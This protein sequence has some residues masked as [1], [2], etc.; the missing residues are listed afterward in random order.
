MSN[1]TAFTV[2][3]I[4]KFVCEAGKS[5][6]FF[7]DASTPGLGLR[8][9]K[10]GAKSYIF[11]SSKSGRITI[12]DIKTW[13]LPEAK[14]RATELKQ[15]VDNG[16]DPRIVAQQQT[17]KQQQFVAEQKRHSI[18]VGEVWP[19][20]VQVNQ[21]KWGA[22]YRFM[23]TKL[24]EAGGEPWKRGKGT[25]VPGPLVPVMALRMCD[26]T[27][28]WIQDWLHDE[29]TVKKR[30]TQARQG[31]VFLRAFYNWCESEAEYRGLIPAETFISKRVKERV[32]KDKVK[33]N[34]CLQREHLPL[35]FKSV[36]AV[37]TY[38]MS[39]YLQALLITGARRNEMAG[40]KWDDL[41]FDHGGTMTLRDKESCHGDE[42]GTRT[43][44]L[45]P[46]LSML[47]NGLPRRPK[48][49]Y[50]FASPKASGGHVVSPNRP[51][52]LMLKRA[53]LPHVSLHGLRR[54]FNTLSEW[55]EIPK[56]VVLQ[57]MGHKPQGVNE[58]R[59]TRRP[60]DL[61]RLH[62]CRFEKWLLQ[63]AGIEFVY[64]VIEA[65]TPQLQLVAA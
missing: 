53:G 25:T 57:I 15:M 63:Q 2:A 47:I 61:L 39:V 44:P 22:K 17:E 14:K 46:Y 59:Y 3:S 60:V 36:L 43:I 18:T 23:E 48:N 41:N 20:Y 54:S 65:P 9:T 27:P 51:N 4:A 13:P 28:K 6:S 19:I 62:H 52:Q 10:A 49:P 21:H 7:R 12:G 35:W 31:F 45:T 55:C 58:T 33:V 11:E 5:Q 37:D 26:L 1:T 16:L 40:L 24:K 32:P 64:P 50:V 42:E 8:V 56:G 34:D 30:K 29:A 38:T